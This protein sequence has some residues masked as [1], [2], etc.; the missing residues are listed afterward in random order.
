V[1]PSVPLH[2]VNVRSFS[3]DYSRFAAMGGELGIGSV[4]P[5]LSSFFSR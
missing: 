4:R 5:Q 3:P 2:G 1:H